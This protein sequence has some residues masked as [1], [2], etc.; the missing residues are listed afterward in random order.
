MVELSDRDCL[1]VVDVQNDFC[2]GG[3]LAVDGGEEVVPVLNR[4]VGL[5]LDAGSPVVASRDWHP[6]DHSSFV[7]RG[8]KWPSHCVQG[9]PGADFHPDLDLPKRTVVV[10]KATTRDDDTYS[11]FDGTG[12]AQLLRER[13]IER[14]VVGGLALDYCVKATVID[15]VAAGFQVRLLT[16]A[17]RSVNLEPGD[18]RR[19]IAQMREA[20]AEIDEES[21]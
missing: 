12:L 5:A 3:A 20:G 21:K 7:E 8:G 1:L 13:G 10:S 4:L 16:A 9:T 2:A 15:A 17:T 14:L 18:D 6:A 19:A 11:A